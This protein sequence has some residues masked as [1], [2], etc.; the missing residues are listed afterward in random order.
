MKG[1]WQRRGALDSDEPTSQVAY[2]SALRQERCNAYG[3]CRK[4]VR[5]H[6]PSHMFFGRRWVTHPRQLEQHLQED[7]GDADFHHDR[8]KGDRC[9]HVYI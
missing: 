8:A 1:Y 7:V 9:G 3:S 5:P 6:V 4:V 2:C